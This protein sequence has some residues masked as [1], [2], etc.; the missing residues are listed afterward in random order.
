MLL[1]RVLTKNSIFLLA[2]L[3]ACA[4]QIPPGGGPDDKTPPKVYYSI[5]MRGAVNVSATTAITLGFSEWI[6]ELNPEKFVTV[7]PPP[8]G[9]FKVTVSGK[10][11]VVKPKRPLADSTTYHLSLNT[12]LTDLHGN[13]IGTPYEL[14]FSTGPTID[15]GRIFGCVI[16]SEGKLSQPKVALF[17]SAAADS[18]D[19]VFFGLPSYLTQTD[20]SGLFSFD[21][22]H[23]GSYDC[24]AFADDDNNNRLGPGRE[25]AF[26]PQ[27]RRIVL[28]K[29]FG[30]VS[31]YPV[32]CDTTSLRLSTVKPV[33]GACIY[34]EWTGAS[35]LVA[36]AWDTSWHIETVE[37]KRVV[38]VAAYVP[39]VNSRR[40]YLKLSDTL[41]RA[42]FK[43]FTI[44]KSPLARPGA[45]VKG[46]TIRFNGII[47]TDTVPPVLKSAEPTQGPSA[48]L[49]P[50]VRLVWSKPVVANVRKWS[51]VDSL[52][53]SVGVTVAAGFSDT[54]LFSLA[55]S[56]VPDT[57]YTMK[58][59]D[60][61]FSDI[62]GNVPKDTAGIRLSFRTISDR[63]LCYSL[64]GGMPCFKGGSDSVAAG[65][66]KWVYLEVGS[67]KRYLSPDVNGSFRFDSIPAGHGTMELFT[68]LNRDGLLTKGS[69][70]PWLAPEPFRTFPDTVEARKMWDI[71]GVTLSGECVE[72]A[73]K[74]APQPVDS[75]KSK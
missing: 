28:E 10:K 56:L 19:T 29:V 39:V 69:L 47:A 13:S 55:K 23:R 43:L 63:D 73:K 14:F 35:A 4:H 22:I 18:S 38:T 15:S 5:P 51:L 2:L 42:A 32:I 26:A 34:G 1:M 75:T 61:V 3:F 37:K 31:L 41:G 70:S 67:A 58:F 65:L 21:N 40:F 24:I 54:T 64:S 48:D 7:F 25:A 68:D 57:K 72:C 30:P 12:A 9:G 66:R 60:S 17:P 44:V 11:L 33:S 53:D 36:P 50:V 59:P 16:S 27:R 62:S 71:E 52:G 74:T 49:K 46:D 45:S 20:S 6:Q 8:A